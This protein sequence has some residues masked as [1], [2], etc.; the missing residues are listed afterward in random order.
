MSAFLQ[1][2]G[3]SFAYPGMA[4]PLFA[5]VAAHF[6]EGS[7][8]GIAGANGAGKTTLLRLA[9]GELQ[10]S[11]G[12]I[13]RS[14][15]AQYVV[16]R[17]DAPPEGWEEFLDAWD[18]AAMDARRLL[19]VEPE[20]AGRWDSLSH[21]ERKRV[22]IAS[23]LWRG[24]EVLALDE[25]T[26]HLDAAAKGVL[27]AALKGFRGVGLVVSH[28]RDFL[29]E[30]CSQCLFVFPPN[31]SLNFACR[32]SKADKPNEEKGGVG[33]ANVRKRLDLLFEDHYTLNIK[34]EPKVYTVELN[35]PLT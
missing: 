29:D 28:D 16:Q 24:P 20:W 33:L 34:D 1:F 25:P 6:P 15:R 2:D 12:S 31:E 4:D 10:P 13:R 9:A 18:P 30:L 14:G 19:G 22:Q 3:V 8:T 23:A 26:N 32:N 21:G 17:T 11:L 7:W 27:L 35:I 5:G